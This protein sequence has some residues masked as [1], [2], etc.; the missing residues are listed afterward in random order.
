MDFPLQY[1]AIKGRLE[2]FYTKNNIKL[3]SSVKHI[4]KDHPNDIQFI[5]E[6]RKRDKNE[7]NYNTSDSKLL[8]LGIILLFGKKI[9]KEL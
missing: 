4:L 6:K 8:L 9:I 3:I 1:L 5:K 2:D 7:E